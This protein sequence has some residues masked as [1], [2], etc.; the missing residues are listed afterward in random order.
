MSDAK[1]P[2]IGRILVGCLRFDCII[3]ILPQERLHPQRLE[4]DIELEADFAAAARTDRIEDTVDYAAVAEQIHALA[5]E[6]QYELVEKLLTEA[7]ALVLEQFPPVRA[8]KI[9]ARKPDILPQTDF[10]GASL[11]MRRD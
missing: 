7:C 10:V 1:T 9:T 3:G 6:H 4:L 8:V 2:F 11:E 5:V